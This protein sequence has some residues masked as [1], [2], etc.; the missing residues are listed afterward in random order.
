MTS[1]VALFL[2]GADFDEADLPAGLEMRLNT[3]NDSDE[4]PSPEPVP[5]GVVG[6][7]WVDAEA[8]QIAEGPVGRV[9]A[10]EM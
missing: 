7:A 2:A 4:E 10:F 3:L 5:S 9:G 1:A 8:S 6:E